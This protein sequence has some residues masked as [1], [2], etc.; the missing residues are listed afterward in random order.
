MNRDKQDQR[1]RG[2][3]YSKE[4]ERTFFFYAT[5]AM[6]VFYMLSRLLSG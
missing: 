1:K 6:F 3:R 2:F 4:S 5:M